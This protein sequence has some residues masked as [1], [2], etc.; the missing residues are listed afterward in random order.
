MNMKCKLLI[1]TL[2][3]LSMTMTSAQSRWY[4]QATLHKGSTIFQNHCATCHK[5]NAEGTLNWK[6]TDNQGNLP[7]PP[8]NGTAH[9]WHHDKDVL[10]NTI[11]EGG[12]K[13]GGT[14]PA[15]KDKL[16]DSDIDAAI[17]Y[18]QSKWPDKLYQNWENRNQ[19]E[20][21]PPIGSNKNKPKYAAIDRNKITKFLKLRIGSDKVSEPVETPV[22][23]I[24]L[25]QFGSKF[26]YLTQDGRFAFIGNLIDLELGANLTNLTRTKTPPPAQ[27]AFIPTIK[28]SSIKRKMTDL[29]KA[30]L[31]SNNVSEPVKTSVKG[32]YQVQFGSNFAYITEGG[33]YAF[34]ANL[35]DLERGL[36]LT[37]NAQRKSVKD[38]MTLFA[39]EDKAIFPAIGI[40]KAVVDIF[41]DTSCSTC[42]KLFKEVPK[43]QEAG[44]SVRYLP[45]PDAGLKGAG[46]Q[47]LK[48][49]W[50]SENKAEALT[51]GKGMK[52]GNLPTGECN[53]AKLVDKGYALGNKVGVI[54]TP[55]IFKANGEQIK[56]YVPSEKL[57]P[58]I[59]KN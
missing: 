6:K 50:C 31:G 48:Q 8:L 3:I 43:L 57:I 15:F 42:K 5:A 39:I 45:F 11:R 44:I 53:N 52:Q 38:E 19:G 55:A 16:S 33:R 51:I 24:Y 54:G 26:A 13:L 40:E 30:S 7:P 23:G 47:T 10:T 12:A 18:F 28:E 4:D 20:N 49:V 58:M 21:I 25:S 46:Y 34:M 1:G 41:T 35:I 37:I 32:I 17:A 9:A 22:D 29:F 59:L 14:M 56:G 2:I 27:K 36:N